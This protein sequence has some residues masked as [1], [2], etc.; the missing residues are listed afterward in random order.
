MYAWSMPIDSS[1][2]AMAL[3]RGAPPPSPTATQS[4]SRVGDRNMSMHAQGMPDE[5]CVAVVALLQTSSEFIEAVA[6]LLQRCKVRVARHLQVRV[7]A[8]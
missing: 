6:Q 8:H 5:M 3:A 4:A 7:E 2:P 1:V